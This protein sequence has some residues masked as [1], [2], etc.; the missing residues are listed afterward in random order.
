MFRLWIKQKKMRQTIAI[1]FTSLFVGSAYSQTDSNGNPVFNSVTVAEERFSD[2]SVSSNYYTLSNNIDNENSSVFISEDPSLKQ[3]AEA[4][5]NLPS[6]FFI[7]TK[8]SYMTNMIMMLDTPERIFLVIDPQSGRKTEYACKLKGDI[9]EN[10][11]KEIID[12]NFD[13]SAHIKGNYLYFNDQ[14]LKVISNE[15]LK[16]A[17]MSL[18]NQEQLAQSTNDIKLLSQEEIKQVVLDESKEGGRLDFF[19]KI[20]GEENNGIQIKPGVFATKY[21]VALYQWGRANFDLGVNTLEDAYAL[22]SEYKSREINEREKSYIKMGFERAW[23]Q[24]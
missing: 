10:R 6:D 12:K 8:G 23:E 18:I 14:K 11:A 3:I 19:T 4:A 9:S 5:V 1:L 24:Q 22:F 21:S 17:I 20:K 15:K 2:F 13:T 16:K 7:I